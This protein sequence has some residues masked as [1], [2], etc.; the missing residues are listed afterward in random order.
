MMLTAEEW[1]AWV[2]STKEASPEAQAHK[3][4]QEF[5][6]AHAEKDEDY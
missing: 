5:A 4:D 6:R 2:L 1:N 3:A